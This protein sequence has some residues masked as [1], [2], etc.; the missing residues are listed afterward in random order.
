MSLYAKIVCFSLVFFKYTTF[1][2]QKV[3][4]HGYCNSF[5]SEVDETLTLTKG[6]VHSSLLN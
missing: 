6:N 4:S 1:I 2:Y 5:L 3:E